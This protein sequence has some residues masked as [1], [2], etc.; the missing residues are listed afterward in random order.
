MAGTGFEKG[1]GAL[2]YKKKKKKK[3]MCK[4][5]TTILQTVNPN[6]VYFP[7][8][9][10]IWPSAIPLCMFHRYLSDKNVSLH[11]DTYLHVQRLFPIDPEL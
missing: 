6:N 8:Y 10:M 5:C 11:F 4:R 1:G 2:L 9:H 7:L 3:N